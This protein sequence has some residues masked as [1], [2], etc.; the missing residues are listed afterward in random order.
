M[1]KLKLKELEAKANEIGIDVIKMITKAGSGH[2]AGALGMADIIT[3][4]YFNILIHDPKKPEWEER[5]RLILSNGHI[6]PA[7]Y[8]ALTGSQNT[9][10]C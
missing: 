9:T 2:P 4:L 8:A 1:R 10:S 7:Q 6:C 5:D 3:A